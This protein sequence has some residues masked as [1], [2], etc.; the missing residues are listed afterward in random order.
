MPKGTVLLTGATGALGGE[1][2]SHLVN[3]DYRVVALVRSD[4]N[5]HAQT[6]LPGYNSSQVIAIRGDI[7][8]PHCGISDIDY[9]LWKNEINSIIHCAASIS[10]SDGVAADQANIN[11]VRHA[12]DLADLLGV[13]DFRH[14]STTYIAGDASIFCED[15]LLVGQSWRNVYENSKYLGEILVRAWG[16]N[17]IRRYTILRPSILLGRENG[18]TPTFDA[19]YGYFRPISYLANQMRR[20]V[21][22]GDSLPDGVSVHE[23]GWVKLPIVLTANPTSTLNLISIDWVAEMITTLQ[24]ERSMNKCFHFA[25]PEPPLVRDVI[26]WS[27]AALKVDGVIVAKDEIE[28]KKEKLQQAPR[29]SNLQKKIIDPVVAQ[30]SPYTSHGPNFE[31]TVTSLSIGRKYRPPRAIDEMYLREMMLFAEDANWG[32]VIKT[33]PELV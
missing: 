14:V 18:T 7:T 32:E 33:I 13:R 30:F 19:Y 3:E 23:D 9:E 22:K 24:V 4:N 15:N 20:K 10:F 26:N 6:R 8:D 27:L 12:L 31:T 21:Q 1:I 5:E 11:G 25:H 28:A 17:S 16:Q 29:L 2:L